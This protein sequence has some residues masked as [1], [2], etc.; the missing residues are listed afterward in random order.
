[1]IGV[2]WQGT[3]VTAVAWA[4]IAVAQSA[5]PYAMKQGPKLV[6][7]VAAAPALPASG[8]VVNAALP[9]AAKPAE[10]A[11]PAKDGEAAPEKD[12]A[13]AAPIKPAEAGPDMSGHKII[14]VQEPGRPPEQC[15][16]I[17]SWPERNG[18][19]ALE[20]QSIRTGERLTVV[21]VGESS[22]RAGMRPGSVVQTM[23]TQI[24]HWTRNTTP[25][26][27]APVA[28]ENA[29]VQR[30]KLH[31]RPISNYRRPILAHRQREAA[32]AATSVASNTRPKTPDHKI[33]IGGTETSSA[34]PVQA[35]APD[36][37]EAKADPEPALPSDWHESWGKPS[38]EDHV[39]KMPP[40]VDLPHADS[41][42]PD[43]LQDPQ[44]Y[45]TKAMEEAG[46]DQPKDKGEEQVAKI[47]SDKPKSDELSRP[48]TGSVAKQASA[49]S[50]QP[51][52]SRAKPK[53]LR[54]VLSGLF[55]GSEESQED[56]PH[57]G[58]APETPPTHP[59]AMVPAGMGGAGSVMAAGGM[60]L[61]VPLV[62]QPNLTRM[63]MPPQA[64][65]PQ[66]PPAPQHVVEVANAFTNV[67]HVPMPQ[68]QQPQQVPPEVANA[69]S[70][71]G[72]AGM[73]HAQPQTHLGATAMVQPAP[74]YAMVQAPPP[75]SGHPVL[76]RPA[77]PNMMA[78][79][80]HRAM[81][82][83]AYQQMMAQQQLAAQQQ[84]MA[85]QQMI[86]QQ[87]PMY[88]MAATRRSMPTQ[89]PPAAQVEQPA[90][91]LQQ[92]MLV[93]R[94]SLWPRHREWAADELAKIDWRA[95]PIVAE[96]IVNA[97]QHDPAPTVRATCVR[98]L[99]KMKCNTVAVVQALQAMK[100]KEDPVVAME[101]ETV[102]VGFLG[103]S[104][105]RQ[106][107][108]TK[109]AQ[110]DVKTAVEQQQT[111]SSADAEQPQAPTT[112]AQHHIVVPRITP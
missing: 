10:A 77:Y 2:K 22:Y 46:A 8:P 23:R 11:D 18:N 50:S 27:G 29:V 48:E 109:S 54:T 103:N 6:P 111:G 7:A 35:P 67:S 75:P 20:V 37:V 30:P 84:M 95:Q 82:M 112:P 36:P 101:I 79:Q 81:Q 1:M 53:T 86:A 71:P 40:K 15:W 3:L 59:M 56:K 72:V 80:Q 25:P 19:V 52:K 76:N 43:P 41:T 97:A 87:Q 51:A 106:A 105:V 38:P 98:S 69:F 33:S 58:V 96:A 108:G 88:Q 24:Y 85:Q 99:G 47:D 63:P 42:K 21:T 90:H 89:L 83:A 55:G 13:E 45:N 66:P 78:A 32:E 102:L 65:I 16:V 91:D 17:R 44:Q 31:E 57:P 64:Q 92:L 60:Y 107:S 34:Q 73:A 93:L 74:V 94:N 5:S 110:P 28:P 39:S 61:P 62:T 26:P 9:P 104:G 68:P 70:T 49:K 4:G 100:V 12:A 14:T